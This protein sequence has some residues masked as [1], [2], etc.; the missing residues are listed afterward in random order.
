MP[1][2]AA[3]GRHVAEPQGCPGEHDSDLDLVPRHEVEELRG[4]FGRASRIDLRLVHAAALCVRRRGDC[5]HERGRRVVQTAEAL[6][7]STRPHRVHVGIRPIAFLHG[8][9]GQLGKAERLDAG[10]LHGPAA[11]SLL[12]PVERSVASP[13]QVSCHPDEEAAERSPRVVLREQLVRAVGVLERAR[14]SL[15]ARG[16]P[17]DHDAALQGLRGIGRRF[18][19][20]PR[21]NLGPVLRAV[22]VSVGKLVGRPPRA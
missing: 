9:H 22:S 7:L 18:P 3:R 17:E 20:P 15:R 12:E 13:V 2:L 11:G 6:D 21:R 10:R 14:N 4:E 5:E 1:Q 19:E 8:E 16:R